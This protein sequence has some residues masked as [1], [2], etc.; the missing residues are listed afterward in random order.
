MVYDSL[1]V[2]CQRFEGKWESQGEKV[3]EERDRGPQRLKLVRSQ[4]RGGLKNVRFSH[5]A[6]AGDLGKS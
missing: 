3:S 5:T 2:S 4:V 6:V 1:Q